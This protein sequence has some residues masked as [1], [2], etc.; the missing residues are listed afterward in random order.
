MIKQ[1]LK[2]SNS[3]IIKFSNK[4]SSKLLDYSRLQ[5]GFTLIE[6][7]V[8]I[9]IVTVILAV[10][11]PNFMG[12]RQRSRDAARKSDLSQ[13]QKA[14]E[15]YK[16]DQNPQSYPTTGAF[17]GNAC[18]KCW[19]QGGIDTACPSGNIYM[20]KMPCDPASP[21]TPTPY[22]YSPDL[23][24]NLKYELYS[25]LENEVDIDRDSTAQPTCAAQPKM[26]YT[27]HEP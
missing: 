13:I 27:I 18:G 23:T 2:S 6:I 4:N 1:I 5:A 14:L 3:Q 24:D 12:A 19:T 16:M 26:S 10:L 9:A 7:L 25:C 8:V 20:R 15:L 17:G 22:I 11:F 21:N